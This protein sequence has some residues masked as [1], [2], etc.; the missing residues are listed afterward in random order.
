[1]WIPPLSLRRPDVAA[2]AGDIHTEAHGGRTLGAPL[3]SFRCHGGAC[4]RENQTEESF[5][6]S[7]NN[8]KGVEV[9]ILLY[10]FVEYCCS[11]GHL[12]VIIAFGSIL[13]QFLSEGG[14]AQRIGM[15]L[16]DKLGKK[17]VGWAI[18]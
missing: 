9:R 15:T 3:Y 7:L 1:M 5:C 13:G 11:L 18:A 12:G 4:A 16:V 2:E 14:A 6:Y 17:R 10:W 8:W